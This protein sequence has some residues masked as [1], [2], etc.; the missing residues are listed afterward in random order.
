VTEATPATTDAAAPAAT[1]PRA[2][3]RW[4]AAFFVLAGVGIVAGVV[5]ALLAPGCLS[6][7]PS[8]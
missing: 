6:C 4:R 5:W 2:R 7:G 3:T 1:P 8:R